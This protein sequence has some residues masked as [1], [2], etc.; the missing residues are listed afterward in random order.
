MIA[1]VTA[2]DG[3]ALGALD[4]ELP[5]MPVPGLWVRGL[6]PVARGRPDDVRGLEIEFVSWD[7][8]AARFGV[9]VHIGKYRPDDPP[10]DAAMASLSDRFRWRVF[11]NEP[12]PP[13]FRSRPQSRARQIFNSILYLFGPDPRPGS[14][15]PAT[16][17]RP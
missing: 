14:T 16:P 2:P 7:L 8:D 17:E 4:L 15:E 12:A 11:R 5:F 13:E 1:S 3:C 9:Q 6:G 10:L